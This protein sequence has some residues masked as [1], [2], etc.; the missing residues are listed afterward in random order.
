M[1]TISTRQDRYLDYVRRVIAVVFAWL[2]TYANVWAQTIPAWPDLKLPRSLQLF[3]VGQH[4]V[5]NGLPM[6]MHGFVSTQSPADLTRS[7]E[8]SLGKPVVVNKL[9]QQT[10][11]GRAQGPHYIT[12][13]IEPASNGSRGVVSITNLQ[14]AFSNKDVTMQERQR[15][16][17]QL[18]SGTIVSSHLKSLDDLKHSQ[19]LIYNNALDENYNRDRLKTVLQTEGLVFERETLVDK[20]AYKGVNSALQGR[21]LFFKGSGKEAMATIHRQSDGQTVTVLNI[22]NTIEKYK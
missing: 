16:I 6:R 9:G 2:L 4:V 14:S 5:M 21:V 1:C 19:Q 8:E 10:V 20:Q 13:Q 11:L 12:V 22:I 18:P 3:S 15:W 17:Q 7:I